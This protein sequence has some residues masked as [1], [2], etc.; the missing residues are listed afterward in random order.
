VGVPYRRPRATLTHVSEQLIGEAWQFHITLNGG[1]TTGSHALP[2]WLA[3]EAR[4]RP[5]NTRGHGPVSFEPWARPNSHY[6]RGLGESVR[7]SSSLDGISQLRTYCV[8]PLDDAY[9]LNRRD[10]V[11]NDYGRTKPTDCVHY[12]RKR[13]S[14]RA[15]QIPA[16]SAHAPTPVPE[17]RPSCHT[18]SSRGRRC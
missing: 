8:A 3:I 17:S 14:T 16:P 7:I 5:R 15:A 11:E 2:Q 12:D 13:I 6:Q 18:P 4:E 9:P 10:D 1:G